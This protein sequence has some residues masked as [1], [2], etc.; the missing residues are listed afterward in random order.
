MKQLRR[1]ALA[2]LLTLGMLCTLCSGALALDIESHWWQRY[3]DAPM[4][5]YSIE[6][7]TDGHV[8]SQGRYVLV[9]SDVH[10]YAYLVA[11]L[12]D[13]ANSIIAEDGG[14][15][16]VGLMAFGG[17]FANEYT[18]Y[19]DNMSI[20]KAALQSSPGTVAAYTKG[21]HEGSVSD[22]DF[23]K[24]TGMCRIG[25]TVVNED[26]AYRFFNF[27]SK[28]RN[29]QF[30]AED[31]AQLRTYLESI[32][33]DD[34]KP[35]V[36]VSHYP[37]HYYNDRRSSKQADQVLSLL[38]DYPQAIFLWGHNH[39]EQDPN[40]G[41]IRV[42][43]DVIQTGVTADTTR[44][45]K[46][47][48]GCLGA[49]RDGI[50]GANGLLMRFDDDGTTTFRYIS[51]NAKADAEDTWTDAQGNENPVRYPANEGVSTTMTAAT[52]SE[53]RFQTIHLANVQI[54]RPLV[55]AAPATSASEYSERFH[56]GEITWTADGAAVS[57]SYDFDTA[58][59]A[60]F[61]LTA[62][63][64]YTFAQDAAVSVNKKYVGPMDGQENN[65]AQVTVAA[66]GASADVTYTFPATAAQ[67]STPADVATELAD[68]VSYVL[69]TTSAYNTAASY[70]YD[71]AQHGE[72]SMPDY[73]VAAA[74]AVIRDGKLVSAPQPS[75]VF[76]AQ[77][78][79]DGYM[80]WSDA[81][82][83]DGQGATTLNYLTMSTRGGELGIQAA[84]MPDMEIYTDWNVD[85]NGLP[86]LNVD[87][88][89]RYP[90]YHGSTFGFTDTAADCNMRLYQVGSNST[91]Y[92]VAVDVAVPEPGQRPT[93]LDALGDVYGGYRVTD[94]KWDTDGTFGY[95]AS[96]TVT[97]T[98]E[99]KS[100]YTFV[101]PYTGRISGNDAE[102]T[103][104][105]NG[106][107]TLRYTFA[108][109]SEK[110]GLTSGLRAK[111]VNAL[112]QGGR[113]VIVSGSSAMR[114]ITS[115]GIYLAAGD[116]TVSGDTISG[117]T[118]DMVFT[119]VGNDTKGYALEQDGRYQAGCSVNG[120]PDL[121]GFTTTDKN[122]AALTWSFADNTLTVV[123]TGASA[124]PGGPPPSA[125][126]NALYC[127]DG[128]FNFSTLSASKIRIFE[129][130]LP[131]T[132]VAGDRWSYD[133]I[134]Q[135]AENGIVNGVEPTEFQPEAKLTRAMAVTM[136]YRMAGCPEATG[137][138]YFT[139]VKQ[140]Y[141]TDALVWA[142]QNKIIL[143]YPGGTFAPD[144]NITREEACV[145]T[146]R[147]MG[148]MDVDGS[149]TP[150]TVTFTDAAK[151]SAY[152]KDDVAVCAKAG[153]I[154]GYPDG[155]FQPQGQITREE[156]AAMFM[157]VYSMMS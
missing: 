139:D 38:N 152:A 114:S 104:N 74:D 129:V 4:E 141:Y 1:R 128:H 64:G 24:Q 115:E 79:S 108:A 41:M 57:G 3:V 46:F 91:V 144:K 54:Q 72:E 130:Y 2:L 89:I 127:N 45:I 27:G 95:G 16:S 62:E 137:K 145:M 18:L 125:A 47:T 119:A 48:Y 12:L 82:L 11:E 52:P 21:N 135:A 103:D 155:T 39:T 120:T 76:T 20:I 49:L 117:I 77:R 10:R 50:N 6:G 66:D 123:S 68:G 59:T 149:D 42:P 151:I 84:E 110:P 63:V 28:D 37:L 93:T 157:R 105:G 85:E 134:Y 133:T 142:V 102:V 88:A 83:L 35:I 97:A 30:T 32:P 90:V 94:L 65:L 146:A 34:H 56:A 58:Y 113:Y 138:V 7:I 9:T 69:A 23:Q 15:G 101:K 107:L 86:Y 87:G 122:S 109:T 153:V 55:D 17:D 75:T 51:L 121:W 112:K 136:L 60:S 13:T 22:E 40:Y 53:E 33:A 98:V 14:S 116:V 118:R 148:L 78:D 81:S 70:L 26:G 100:G 92:N 71:P 5:D 44:E 67:S 150:Q 140:T 124:G 147:F 31:I 19:A 43:G 154:N 126:V 132:D 80:L 111:E 99:A 25:E 61:T 8:T 36:I 131:F 73:A 106:T 96:Y 29:Q 156:A 143:G